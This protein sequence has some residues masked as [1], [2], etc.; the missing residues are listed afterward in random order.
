MGTQNIAIT[1]LCGSTKFKT[2]FEEA[3][4][5][6]EQSG[7]FVVFRPQYFMH[8]EGLSD[9]DIEKA[10]T[11]HYFKMQNSNTIHVINPGG[12]IGNATRSEIIF[13]MEA[14]LDIYLMD[15]SCMDKIADVFGSLPPVFQDAYTPHK[16]PDNFF[17]KGALIHSG[18]SINPV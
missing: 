9:V 5:V 2:E 8:A 18:S 4:R 6:L 11:L 10:T 7:K 3:A 16:F 14:M 1:T 17:F 12:Y 13:A 15:F